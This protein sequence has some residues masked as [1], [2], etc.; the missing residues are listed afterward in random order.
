MPGWDKTFDWTVYFEQL[1]FEVYKMIVAGNDV[2]QGALA[3]ERKEDHVYVHLIESAP[4]N[5]HDKVFDYIGEHLIAF[6]CN[7]S[8]DLGFDGCIAFQSKTKQRL[9]WHYINDLGARHLGGGYMIIS[10]SV[11]ERLIMLYLS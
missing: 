6:A 7:R 3:L 2:I 10:E 4:H 5:R 11:A 1:G 9:M 8:M